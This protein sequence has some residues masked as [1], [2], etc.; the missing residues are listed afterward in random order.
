MIIVMPIINIAMPKP[1]LYLLV[2]DIAIVHQVIKPKLPIRVAHKK[3]S[4]LKVGY[5]PKSFTILLLVNSS[6]FIKD[7]LN[8]IFTNNVDYVILKQR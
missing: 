5:A 1:S 6:F 8:I 7:S 4:G 2:I 3:I